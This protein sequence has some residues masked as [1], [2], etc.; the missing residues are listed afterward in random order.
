LKANALAL[1]ALVALALAGLASAGMAATA[2]P[3]NLRRGAHVSVTYHPEGPRGQAADEV[4]VVPPHAH[5]PSR[6]SFV[7]VTAETEGTRVGAVR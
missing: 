5:V 3:S 1:P 7:A 2:V 6:S 4:Q